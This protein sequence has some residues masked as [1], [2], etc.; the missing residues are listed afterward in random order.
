MNTSPAPE[1]TPEPT[2]RSLL[3]HFGDLPDPRIDRTRRHELTDIPVIAICTLL[4]GGESFNDMED[5]GL[6]KEDWLR[7][8]LALPHGI[9]THDTFN[10]V[11]SAL[12]P[13]KFLDCFMRWTQD[14]RTTV[15]EEIVAMDGKALRRALAGQTMPHIVSAWAVR[16]GLVLGQRRVNDKSNEIT[17]IPEL[18][19]VLELGGCIVTID[20]MG[21]QKNIAKEIVEADAHYVLALKGNQ[22]TVHQEVR[23]FLDDT[24]RQ[25]PSELDYFQTVEK[26][27]GRLETRRYWQSDRLDWFADLAQWEGLQSVGVVESIREIKGQIQTERRYFLSSLPRDV[28]RLA[29]AI[30]SHWGVENQLHWVLDVQ[31]NE[32]QSRARV[33][34]AAENLATLRR[35]ALNL[36]KRETTKKRGIRGK[37]KN[38]GWNHAY[39]LRLLGL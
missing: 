22:Q 10:R 28:Q 6:A 34:Y 1:P 37:Q 8:F 29:G 27:H 39:L 14:L 17:A 13:A 36:L 20:A 4:C 11:F 16:S 31:F 7:T 25:R 32:D 18:L 38:A 15:G 35:L 12:D 21:C 9:P 30:R 23:D 19:R 33:G 26:D 5:F 3:E 24:L 2:P